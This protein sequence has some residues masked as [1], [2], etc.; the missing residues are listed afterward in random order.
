MCEV[1]F[2]S[3]STLCNKLLC[4]C[5][6]ACK[7]DI[8]C[9]IPIPLVPPPPETRVQCEG[10]VRDLQQINPITHGRWIPLLA[11]YKMKPQKLPP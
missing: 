4:V 11:P 7:L 10:L 9:K 5:S 6:C 3:N 8:K 1:I 2:I